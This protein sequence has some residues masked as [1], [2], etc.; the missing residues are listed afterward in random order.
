[1]IKTFAP[2]RSAKKFVLLGKDFQSKLFEDVPRE[3]LPKR[4]GG[5]LPDGVQWAQA[6]K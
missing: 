1:M 6:K 2:A 5:V 3:Q 4:L